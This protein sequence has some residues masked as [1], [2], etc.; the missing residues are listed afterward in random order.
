MNDHDRRERAWRVARTVGLVVLAAWPAAVVATIA[1]T[2][3]LSALVTVP[4]GPAVALGAMELVE[5]G[6]VRV[7]GQ[8]TSPRTG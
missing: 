5:R 2:G 7:G 8:V 1:T 6:Q 3:L 4:A